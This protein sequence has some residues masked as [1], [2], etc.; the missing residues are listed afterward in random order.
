MSEIILAPLWVWIFVGEK[1]S[2]STILG[3]AIILLAVVWV[4]LTR[5][6]RKGRRPITS[7]G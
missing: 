6:P 2:A 5:A 4:T 3:G 7:R 1:A